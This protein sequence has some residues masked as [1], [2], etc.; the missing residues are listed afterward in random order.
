MGPFLLRRLLFVFISLIGATATVFSLSRAAGDP[1]LL[2][3]KPAGYGSTEE[4]LDNLRKHLGTDKPLI[5]QYVRWVGQYL[6]G[7]MG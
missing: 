7:D 3:A 6:R 5:V 4:Y 1:V 2:Y